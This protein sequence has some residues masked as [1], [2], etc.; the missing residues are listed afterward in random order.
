SGAVEENINR[1]VIEACR[2]TADTC[3]VCHV[4][5][6]NCHRM[7]ARELMKIMSSVRIAA[8]GEDPPAIF[9]I[10]SGEFQAQGAIGARYHD[11]WHST[12]PRRERLWRRLA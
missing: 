9:R 2:R 8:G 6:Q 10:L 7:P 4:H 1:F 12:S 5:R 3:E 11:R